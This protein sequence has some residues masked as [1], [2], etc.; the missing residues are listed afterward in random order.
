MA[1]LLLK[2]IHKSYGGVE[3]I[4]GL[5]LL[6]RDGKF[7]ALLG[8]SGSGKTTLLQIVAGLETLNSGEVQVNGRD[9]SR[10]LP[11]ARNI[12]VVFQ[13]YALFP[14]LSAADNVAYGLATRRVPKAERRRRVDEILGLVGLGDFAQR[15]PAEL[16]G[17]QQ[18]RVALARALVIEPDLLLLD[19]PLSALDKRI[20]QEMQSELARIHDETGLTTVLVTHDQEEALDLADQVVL[21]NGGIIQQDEAPRHVYR[22]PANAFVADFLGAQRFIATGVQTPN[23]FALQ[24][25]DVL[26]VSAPAGDIADGKSVEVA[27]LPEAVRVSRSSDGHAKITRLSFFGP[28]VRLTLGFDDGLTIESLMTSLVAQNLEVGMGVVVEVDPMGI[29]VLGSSGS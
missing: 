25:G 18:Q 6:V 15:K 10:L 29:Q 13:S 11:E 17:G 7:C 9:I 24:L 12:G 5:N 1:D 26:T 4:S 16:S 14:H 2:N 19:E 23:G 21:L 28:T 27:V 22:A 3:V 8:P 20:R